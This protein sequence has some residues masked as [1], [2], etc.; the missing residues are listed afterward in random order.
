VNVYELRFKIFLL[1]TIRQEEALAVISAFIDSVLV[2]DSEWKAF[3]KAR[4]FKRYSFASF[5]PLA[6][7][8]IYLKENVYQILIRTV[9]EKLALYLLENLSSYSNDDMKG[10][11]C[12]IQIMPRRHIER[13]YSLSPL[14]V[15]GDQNHY[16]RDVLNF[17][18]FEQ[19]LTVNLIKK[20]NQISGKKLDENFQMFTML[21]LLN[22]HPISVPYKGI[23]LLA[24]KVQ[25]QVAENE[26]AQI[27]ARVALAAGLGEMGSRGYGSVNAKYL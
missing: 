3:H 17:E 26:T 4:M 25:A 13:I 6:K 8:G 7:S 12:N 5:V 27:L 10:L 9:D 20:Y 1:R 18:E 14:I 24:D 11:I 2:N 21:E 23:K 16:W 22:E 15:K 19:R